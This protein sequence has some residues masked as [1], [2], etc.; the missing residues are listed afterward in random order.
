M[1]SFPA[2]FDAMLSASQTTTTPS[3]LI[4]WLLAPAVSSDGL[5]AHQAP[6]GL[7]RIE[8][9]LRRDGWA[10]DEVAVA[11][12]EDLGRAIGPDTKVIGLS[13]GDPLGLGMN[14][15]TMAG[16]AG[17]RS[18]PSA[19]FRQLA[20]RV[21][22]LRRRSPQA[23]VVV[24]GP[25]AWQLAGDDAARAELGVDHVI[26]GY[27]ESAVGDAF[28]RLAAAAA[29]PAVIEA[30]PV[31]GDAVP[32]IL[33]PTVMGSVEV[34]RGCGL[35]CDFCTIGRPAMTHLPAETI[36]AD[37]GTNLQAGVTCA[38][39]VTEDLFRY[40]GSASQ[41]RPDAVIGLLEQIRGLPGLELVQTDHANIASV[42]QFTDEELA[43]VRRLF[44][45]EGRRHDYLWLN[46]GVETACGELLAAHGGRPKMGSCAP[47]DWGEFCLE[48]VH[49]LIRAGFFPLVSL[50]MG[51]PGEGD[52]HVTATTRWIEQL[53]RER[54]AAFPLFYAPIAGDAPAFGIREM[55]REH[56]RLFRT[57]YRLN[58]K[59]MPR[60]SWDNQTA[61]G[62]ALCKRLLMQALGWGQIAWWKALFVWRS[63]RLFP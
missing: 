5:R 4:R 14:S 18:I 54:L 55:S 52:D 20:R 48:Q 27:A 49:R 22:S 2:L 19:W 63:G 40:G 57:C 25:G 41:V 34:S 42:A 11:T 59:W 36:L 24:G 32:A 30:E 62:V 28:R 15:N 6:L 35:G 58:F 10:R 13:S 26:V 3:P 8:A 7:R 33:G 46:L 12:P 21:H 50:L 23:R 17:G 9:A 43:T 37:L 16:I 31:A 29:V 51:M 38:T 53:L 61:A 1:A 44:V 47:E 39:L 56:W 60:L 45:P